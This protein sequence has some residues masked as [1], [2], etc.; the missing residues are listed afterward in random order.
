MSHLYPIYPTIRI[1]NTNSTNGIDFK[2][3]VNNNLTYHSPYNSLKVIPIE[4]ASKIVNPS[5]IEQFY[6]YWISF[7]K[8][9][10]EMNIHSAIE[11]PISSNHKSDKT[12]T[13]D[14]DDVKDT[15]KEITFLIDSYVSKT[16][17]DDD[18]KEEFLI[19]KSKIDSIKNLENLADK[20]S[21]IERYLKNVKSLL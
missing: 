1:N 3:Y 2:S 6:N 4:E 11:Q 20:K 17:I 8:H 7:V 18:L 15:I 14:T 16:D 13:D 10:S 12:V 9:R 21:V 19:I 5:P